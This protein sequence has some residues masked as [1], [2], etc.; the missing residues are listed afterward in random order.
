MPKSKRLNKE[1]FHIKNKEKKHN[2]KWDDIPDRDPLNFIKPF[3][4]L[5]LG[6]V[7]MGKTNTIKNII[8]RVDPYFRKIYLLHCGGDWTKEYDELDYECLSEIPAPNDPRF[9]GEEPTLMIIE[10]KGFENLTRNERK[11][12][13][14]LFGYTSTHRNVS[15]MMTAQ[16]FFD[17]P[18]NVR[19]MCNVIIIWKV[20]DTDLLK[21]IGRRVNYSKEQMLSLA[22]NHFQHHR[23]S[24]WFDG[25]AGSPYPLRKNGYE[26]IDI[27]TLTTNREEP[28]GELED[29]V[30]IDM[31]TSK[32]PETGKYTMDTQSGDVLVL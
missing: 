20:R 26:I 5:A 7:N 11:A 22:E 9:D 16:N 2:E 10:D 29:D 25:S 24:I 19:R 1:L 13:G 12:L 18:A 14:R 21:C 30:K 6:G 31:D 8:L 27:K 28:E 15:I 23:D 4:L 17:V 32:E 3:R